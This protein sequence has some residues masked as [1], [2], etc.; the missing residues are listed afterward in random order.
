[1]QGMDQ[2]EVLVELRGLRAD[3]KCYARWALAFGF[4]SLLSMG[5][6]FGDRDEQGICAVTLAVFLIV[7]F[8]IKLGSILMRFPIK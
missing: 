8:L 5:M 7:A 6:I 1:M 2:N 3:L 4:V